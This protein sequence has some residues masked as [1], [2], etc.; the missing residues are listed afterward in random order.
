VK[1]GDWPPGEAPE[2]VAQVELAGAGTAD[3]SPPGELM[4]NNWPFTISGTWSGVTGH[5]SD[6]FLSYT[7]VT[8]LYFGPR[9]HFLEDDLLFQSGSA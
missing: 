5:R 1:R 3:H 6:V 4:V 7:F 8:V 2:A 9:A